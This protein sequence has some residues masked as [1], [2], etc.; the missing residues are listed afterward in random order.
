MLLRETSATKVG[1]QL[2][3]NSGWQS[4]NRKVQHMVN[5]E[6][7]AEAIAQS[8]VATTRKWQKAEQEATRAFIASH[9]TA[10]LKEAT[11][12]NGDVAA[13]IA[14]QMDTVG[15]ISNDSACRQEFEKH[16]IC[17]AVRP[18]PTALTRAI[19]S[20]LPKAS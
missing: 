4:Q 8:G 10:A 12:T 3:N 20:R 17:N 14:E 16:G 1:R 2:A 18:E 11:T 13:I 9:Y 7:L 15:R 6:L 5:I 19:I